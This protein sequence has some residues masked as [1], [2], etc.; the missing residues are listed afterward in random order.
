MKRKMYMVNYEIKPTFDNLKNSILQ[1]MVGRNET[2]AHFI[3]FLDAINQNTAIALDD[4]WGN[5]KTFFVKQTQ[6]VIQSHNSSENELSDIKQCMM[7]YFHNYIP[8]KYIPIYYDAWSNDNDTDPILSIIFNMLKDIDVLTEY[9]TVDKSW[10]DRITYS[11]EL[12]ST[13]FGGPRIKNLLDSIKGKNLLE[14]IKKSKEVDQILNDLFDVILE[15]YPDTRIVF[16]IDELDRCCPNFAVRLL[17]R[18]KHYFLHDKVIFVI[19]VN[20]SELQHTIKRHYGN[21]FNA[22]KY[23]QRFF[24]FTIP[25]PVVNMQKFYEMIQFNDDNVRYEIADLMMNYYNFSLR[26]RTRY[27]QYLKSSIPKMSNND[28]NRIKFYK[29]ILAPF[30]IGLK[31]HDPKKYV[32]FIQGENLSYFLDLIQSTNHPDPYCFILLNDNETFEE[33]NPH[34]K[35]FIPLNERFKFVYK[36]LFGNSINNKSSQLMD[37]AKLENISSKDKK[38]IMEMMSFMQAK[39]NL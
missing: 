27:L 22:N 32:E 13:A 4:T 28:F 10:W 2:I 21:D 24:D 29:E 36:C 14:E 34:H 8:K 11:L 7:K 31:I 38:F 3:E 16:F 19:S 18:I 17:E 6:L 39:E 5:G 1:D 12:I 35:T 33:N 30:L 15:K 20:S 25:L 37:V 26:D 9:E 23:L